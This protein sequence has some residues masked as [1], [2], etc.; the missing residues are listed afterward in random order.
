MKKGRKTGGKKQVVK[1]GHVNAYAEFS[2]A[3]RALADLELRREQDA[4]RAFREEAERRDR[5]LYR[6]Y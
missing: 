4:K 3:D 2:K 5:R 1:T 6:G